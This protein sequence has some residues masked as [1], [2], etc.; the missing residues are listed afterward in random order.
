MELAKKHKGSCEAI[1]T[2]LT[3]GPQNA[4]Q[5]PNVKYEV[6]QPAL[7][8]HASVDLNNKAISMFEKIEKLPDEATRKTMMQLMDWGYLDFDKNLA[9]CRKHGNKINA[10]L[11]DP[12]LN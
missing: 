6:Q 12:S 5:A 1:I 7:N 9:V 8:M 2:E 11:E 4:P 3:E 10:V